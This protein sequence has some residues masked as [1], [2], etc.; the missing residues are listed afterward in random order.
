[1]SAARFHDLQA[2]YELPATAPERFALLLELVSA[3]PV[4]LTSVREPERA[5]EVHVA[6]SLSGL[7]ATPVR[8][9]RAIADLGSGGGFPG[10]V[11]AIALP[12]ATVTLVESAGK[13]AAFLERAGEEL[14]LANVRVVAERVEEWAGGR[15]SQDVVTA[16]ALAPLAVLLEYAAPPLR[17][18]GTLVAWKGRRD[19]AE[20]EGG[21][22]AAGALGMTP[23]APLR[24]QPFAEA[25]ERHLYLSSKV[26]STPNRYPRR[27]GMARKRPLGASG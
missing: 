5:A 2:R 14:G 9:A 3:A 26:S 16:R 6:D 19:A 20:E 8:E 18:G 25:G 4:S 12:D 10:L 1:M 24:V 27:P 22:A 21:A 15:G 7:E 11:L 17:V 13:K 23:P